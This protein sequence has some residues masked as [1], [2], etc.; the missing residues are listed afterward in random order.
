MFEGRTLA[1]LRAAGKKVV[2]K[3]EADKRTGTHHIVDLSP[4]ERAGDKK[5]DT[6]K[7]IAKLLRAPPSEPLPTGVEHCSAHEMG[8]A[9]FSKDDAK[10]IRGWRR[11]KGDEKP[12]TF[13]AFQPLSTRMHMFQSLGIYLAQNYA[14]FER[15]GIDVRDIDAGVLPE[16][17]L[18]PSKHYDR[19]A[20]RYPEHFNNAPKPAP[21]SQKPKAGGVRPSTAAA[22]A[23][24]SDAE[25]K[26]FNRDYEIKHGGGYIQIPMWFA[27]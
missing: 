6:L 12:E 26:Q 17:V 27:D 13:A 3:W 8:L 15:A 24:V 7:D 18:V 20:K 11:F 10:T 21:V 25:V 19:A 9:F 2:I 22:L 16:H 23:P 5:A 1:E 14:S 4:D